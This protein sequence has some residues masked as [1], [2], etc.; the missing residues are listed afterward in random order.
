MPSI[1][2]HSVLFS[3]PRSL[4]Q[5]LRGHT[6]TV[7]AVLVHPL[8]ALQALTAARD[9]TLRTWDFYD[10][11]CLGTLVLGAPILHV[12]APTRPP[13]ALKADVY[14]QIFFLL[15]L[16]STPFLFLIHPFE[17]FRYLSLFLSLARADM[18]SW[19]VPRKTLSG[20]RTWLQT[21]ARISTRL[22]AARTHSPSGEREQCA[23]EHACPRLLDFAP[24]ASFVFNPQL[25]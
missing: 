24:P 1:L 3:T 15:F 22:V 11:V 20:W 5:T 13:P 9:G 25:N 17:L 4:A 19:Q 6:D 2:L 23:R 16:F 14:N 7:T 21:R 12:V 10:G 18:R 8:N